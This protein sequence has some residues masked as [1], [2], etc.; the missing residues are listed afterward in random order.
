MKALRWD[1]LG[2]VG[3]ILVGCSSGMV[4][5]VGSSEA[6]EE[7]FTRL[8]HPK[9]VVAL[10]KKEAFPVLLRNRTAQEEADDATQD[11]VTPTQAAP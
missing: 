5:L 11:Q 6:E 10:Q 9:P 3:L 7:A 8:T 1:R 4:A 2:L